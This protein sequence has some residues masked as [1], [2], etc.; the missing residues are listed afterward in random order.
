MIV[1]GGYNGGINGTQLNTGGKYN[2]NTDSWTDISTTDAPGARQEHTAVWTDSEMIIWG[3][4]LFDG[5]S[6]FLNTGGRYDP[7]T[8]S[9]TGT[10]ILNAP[11][12][13][14][15]HTAVWTG[16]EMIVWGGH[17]E[18]Y[19]LLNT[20]GRYNP[21][22]DNW[23]ATSTNDAPIPRQSHT[24]VWTGNEMIV[25]AGWSGFGG[26]SYLDNGEGYGAQTWAPTGPPTP[27]PT[28]T[29]I[30]T[31]PIPGTG[32]R[33]NPIADAWRPTSTINAAPERENHT[34]VWTGS[35][36]IVWGGNDLHGFLASGGRYCAQSEATPTP[37]P[38]PTPTPTA[39]PAPTPRATPAPRRRPTP[40]PRP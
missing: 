38:S 10:Q 14:R 36:M 24:T 7:T 37:T 33:Y 21:S 8:N 4:Y 6:H 25:W 9:W 26:G 30:P 40:H 5:N 12:G 15:Y 39:T 20:G 27:S 3:G 16:D 11:T 22:T 34:A 13:R 2:P 18:N 29:P 17:D 19:T 35:K 23:I 32:G 28:P 31:P 1:W